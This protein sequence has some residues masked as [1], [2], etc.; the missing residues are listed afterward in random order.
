MASDK[1]E[2][3]ILNNRDAFDAEAPTP[4]LWNRIERALPSD[5]DSPDDFDDFIANHRDAFDDATPTAPGGS[6]NIRPA[7]KLGIRYGYARPSTAGKP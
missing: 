3:F 2:D 5:D 4:E 1:L 6:K 7:R